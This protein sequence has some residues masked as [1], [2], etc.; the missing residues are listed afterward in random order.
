MI[1]KGMFFITEFGKYQKVQTMK[2][3]LP[4]I[5]RKNC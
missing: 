4:T 5:Y 3:K 2:Q 1:L